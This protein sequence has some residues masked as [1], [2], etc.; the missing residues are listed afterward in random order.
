[1]AWLEKT[2]M[3]GQHKY[4]ENEDTGEL[5]YGDPRGWGEQVV[6]TATPVTWTESKYMD[7]RGTAYT[8]DKTGEVV[9]G[10]DATLTPEQREQEF[11]QL[12]NNPNASSWD[13]AQAVQKQYGIETL[14]QLAKQGHF[15][16]V[17]DLG[18]YI[19]ARQREAN[20]AGFTI[21]GNKLGLWPVALGMGAAG[22]YGSTVAGTTSAA[23]A[24]TAAG[25]GST[26]ATQMGLVGAIGESAAAGA[27]TG[28]TGTLA[29]GGGTAAGGV[30]GGA[31]TGGTTI[32]G[33]G[34][35]AAGGSAGTAAATAGASAAG[36]T[37]LSRLL[38]GSA[39]AEDWL[40]LAG[41]LAPAAIGAFAS[42]RQ[43]DRLS[44]LSDKYIEFGGPSRARYEAS[45]APGFNMNMD[46]GYKDALDQTT[47]SFLH[48]ASVT[49]N[50]AD[51]PNAWMQTL[52]DV[53]SSFTMPALNEYRRLNAGTGG[54][55]NLTSAAPG[56]D[57]AAVDAE[58]G[59]YDAIGAG[60]A[61]VFTPRKSLSDL[62]RE[63]RY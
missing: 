57:R 34:T 43:A 6:T 10:R 18:A 39:S 45:F 13:K 46:P 26:T 35:P 59:I 52:K 44:D 17:P 31:A 30:G 32:L 9:Y 5:S 42:D 55:A 8:N 63:A 16:D 29:A 49:G 48:K 54:L 21:G 50:P 61:D 41:R 60:A 4:W 15:A 3:N 7:G 36:A 53:N 2:Y 20:D 12:W 58:R 27:T 22:L 47:K 28:A 37:G 40:D 56:M 51:S 23:A 14:A 1:M 11:M 25:V 62:L 24:P 19:A 33:T 38:D